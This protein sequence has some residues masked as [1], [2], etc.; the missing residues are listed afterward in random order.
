[1]Y[2]IKLLTDSASDLPQDFEKTH[3]VDILC[4]K[5]QLDDVD[6]MERRDFT[7][8][9]FYTILDLASGMPT[10]SQ[11]TVFEFADYFEQFADGEYTDVIYVGINSGGSNTF[12]SATLARQQFYTKHPDAAVKIHLV[13]SHSYSM[14]YGYAVMQ[15]ADMAQRGDSAEQIVDFLNK[16]FEHMNI[17]VAVFDLKH[18][19]KSGR[20][21]AVAAFAG[22]VL[23][24]RPILTLDHGVSAV[25]KKI[26]G[27][28]KVFDELVSFV[29]AD[30]AP[31]SGYLLGYTKR[32]D[33][34]DELLNRC[35][36]RFG[37]EPELCF[38]LGSAVC[39]NLGTD[40]LVLMYT[41]KNFDETLR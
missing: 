40:G 11:I 41:K 24:V 23:G 13:D 29:Q 17:C 18:A 2:K 22:S 1:M 28:E 16:R 38:E 39:A 34:R 4:F 8:R 33:R 15:A 31:D 19:R 10:T 12:A 35:S 14:A 30:M 6:Y 25:Q 5:M 3:D 26:R 21:N 36:E 37:R 9:Q 32:T 27:D 20:L 7:P